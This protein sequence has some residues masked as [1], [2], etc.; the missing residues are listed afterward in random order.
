VVLVDK[1]EGWTSFQAVRAVRGLTGRGVKVGHAGTLDPFATGLLLLLIGQATRVSSFLMD[2]PKEYVVMAQF[3]A[4]SSTQDRTGTLTP[5]GVR[6]T[7]AAVR[8]GLETLRGL[9]RQRVPMTSAVKR[10]GVPLY[11]LAHRGLEVETP[12]RD[13]MVHH[14]DLAAFDEDGQTAV[15]LAG[16]SK[17]TYVRTLVHDLGVALG[18]GA[19]AAELRR[20][21]VGPFSVKDAVAPTDLTEVALRGA[22]GAVKTL[23]EA[24]A[25]L[26]VEHLDAERSLQATRG[27]GLSGTPAGRFRVEGAA[28]LLGIYEGPE[29]AARPVLVFPEPEA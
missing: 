4:S 9:V 5:S 29:G 18:A 15:L 23:S 11:R 13:V 14:L 28:G 26:P 27:S 6:V 21:R 2:L 17:G 20:T 19:Y 1:P 8:G 22:G 10:H 16:T 12:E 24:L 25:F 3:G 7:E